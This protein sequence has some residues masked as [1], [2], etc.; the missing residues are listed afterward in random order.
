MLITT[1]IPQSFYQTLQ[2]STTS[3]LQPF[4]EL[5]LPILFH[6][7]CYQEFFVVMN[8]VIKP[9]SFFWIVALWISMICHYE[10]FA[11]LS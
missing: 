4:L 1:T 11:L 10:H 3:H 2:Y 7:S 9:T 5:L 8:P 6:C